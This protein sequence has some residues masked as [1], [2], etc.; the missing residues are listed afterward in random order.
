MPAEPLD[1]L[2]P[3]KMV[4]KVTAPTRLEKSAM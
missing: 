1:R 3:K 4:K 2:L